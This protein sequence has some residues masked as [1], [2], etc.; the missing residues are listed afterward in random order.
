MLYTIR[1]DDATPRDVVIEHPVRAGWTLTG[2][3]K[4]AESSATAHRFRVAVAP[5]STA[6]LTVAEVR[7]IDQRIT[8]SNISDDQIAVILRGR[9][10]AAGLEPQLRAVAA[11]SREVGADP[12]PDRRSR[13]PRCGGSRTTRRRVREN[14]KALKGSDA[15]KAL[16]ERYTRQLSTQ[17]DRLDVLRK[18]IEAAEAERARE[19]AGAVAARGRAVDR[20]RAAVRAGRE[21]DVSDPLRRLPDLAAHLATALAR[22]L[23]GG[24]DS[25][26]AVARLLDGSLPPHAG[27]ERPAAVLILLFP[28]DGVPHV[29][30][31]VRGAGLPHHA[32][33]ISLPGGRPAPG[34]SAEQTAV[35]EA[36]EEVGVDPAGLAVAGRLTPVHIAV[37]GFTVQPI[38]ALAGTAPTFVAA[39]GEV[40]ALLEVSL[41]VLANPVDPALEP[42][43]PRWH[44]NRRALLRRRRTPGVGRHGDAARRAAR[45][46]RLGSRLAGSTSA[47]QPRRLGGGRRR[48]RRGVRG[49]H[50]LER[51]LFARRD[52][53]QR[54]AGRQGAAGAADAVHVGFRPSAGRRS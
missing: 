40:A 36:V 10:V 39:P 46:L 31:T 12:A 33:R 19:A 53:R 37:S 9:N 16:A 8:V 13:R 1:N 47:W 7:P 15:E 6:T 24:A 4:P 52:Q 54:V 32:D 45:R 48:R 43:R 25:R 20:R 27:R 21:R 50:G 18:E 42:A 29:V 34:E 44:R 14:L 51:A 5:K 30:L 38:V 49:E 3:V 11:K 2:G 35:R 28:R 22:P 26:S 41:P 17:E 23:P